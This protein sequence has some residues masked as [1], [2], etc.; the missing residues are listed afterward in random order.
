MDINKEQFIDGLASKFGVT[1]SQAK[2]LVDAFTQ[3]LRENIAA[4]NNV[5]IEGLGTFKVQSLF[6]SDFDP[7][8]AASKLQPYLNKKLVYFNS[9][10]AS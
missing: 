4:G 8:G 1:K 7:K 10:L 3:A 5:S 9:E 2:I 6:A